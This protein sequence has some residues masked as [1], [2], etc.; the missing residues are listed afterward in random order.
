MIQGVGIDIVEIDRIKRIIE[1]C[2]EGFL[3]FTFTL[4]EIDEYKR[5]NCSVRQLAGKFAIKEAVLKAIGISWQ[6]GIKFKDIEVKDSHNPT[7]NLYGKVKF[8]ADE[9]CIKNISATIS[10]CKKYA[11]GVAIIER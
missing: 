6:K 3:R 9:L 5:K 2:G 10:Y 1:N 11:V 4:L 7:V 8:I